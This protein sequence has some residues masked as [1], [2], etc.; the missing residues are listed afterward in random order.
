MV[1]LDNFFTAEHW[2]RYDGKKVKAKVRYSAQPAEAI[3]QIAIKGNVLLPILQSRSAQLLLDN[4]LFFMR[5]I[6]SLA[7][8]LSSKGW[9][10]P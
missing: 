1:S 9:S 7:V 5:R 3:L 6:R 10:Y 2:S 8:D 4:L